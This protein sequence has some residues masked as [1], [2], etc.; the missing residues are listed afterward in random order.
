MRKRVIAVA[1]FSF[2]AISGVALASTSSPSPGQLY[3]SQFL[4]VTV[5]KPATKARVF[6]ECLPTSGATGGQWLGTVAARWPFGA[7]GTFATG[8]L[9]SGWS[10]RRGPC[11]GRSLPETRRAIRRSRVTRCGSPSRSAL[12]P[13]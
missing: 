12:D 2:A 13:P 5:G 1:L 9:T 4:T 8:T 3:T 7:L 10:F 6:V 11:R